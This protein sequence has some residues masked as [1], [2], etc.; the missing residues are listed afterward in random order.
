MAVTLAS[1][2]VNAWASS[3]GGY[4]N[5]YGS[6]A[7]S[8]YAGP[9]VSGTDCLGLAF[10]AFNGLDGASGVVASSQ[11]RAA[12]W[13]GVGMTSLGAVF[14][15]GYPYTWGEIFYLKNPPTG[16]QN[17]QLVSSGS[18]G[19]GVSFSLNALSYKGVDPA[20]TPSLAVNTNSSQPYTVA[21]T[22]GNRICAM[23]SAAYT[24]QTFL[25]TPAELESESFGA[26]RGWFTLLDTAGSPSQSYTFAGGSGS[27]YYSFAA[28]DI[29]ALA[30]AAGI[31]TMF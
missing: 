7:I 12:Y 8:G 13:G 16:T 10:L 17:I 1:G 25:F 22:A 11:S 2:P 24:G 4:T 3:G 23:F 14:H 20:Y 6:I 19:L 31:L 28:L 18:K 5:S 27:A 29:K 15:S 30:S 9:S 26:S 21:S